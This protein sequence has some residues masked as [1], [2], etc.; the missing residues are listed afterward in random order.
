MTR[1]QIDDSLVR[2]IVREL[3]RSDAGSGRPLATLVEQLLDRQPELLAFLLAGTAQ[4][5]AETRSVGLQLAS[6]IFESFRLAGRTT[7]AVPTGSFVAALKENRD[8]AFRVGQAH[9]RFA[10]RYLKNSNTLHQPALIRYATS[11]L[12]DHDES[13]P[14]SISRE[15]LGPLFIILKSI[16]DVL[17][18]DAATQMVPSLPV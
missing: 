11:V 18:E 2:R 3:P 6:V 15:E 10:E 8:I 5:A 16:I 17:D 9:D 4:L 13:C 12:L 7:R 1:L 14:H